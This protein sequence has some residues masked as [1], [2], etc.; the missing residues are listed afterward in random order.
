MAF[1]LLKVHFT[2]TSITILGFFLAIISAI[3]YAYSV[4]HLHNIAAALLL[5][6]SGLCDVLD[7]AMAR[8][9]KQSSAFGSFLDSTLDRYSDILVI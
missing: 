5:F 1:A 6:S 7:G 3:F 8:L 4:I 2:P 9:G